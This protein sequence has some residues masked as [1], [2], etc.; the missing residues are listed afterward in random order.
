MAYVPP[1]ARRGQASTPHS[2][3]YIALSEISSYV[4][5]NQPGKLDGN[6]RNSSSSSFSPSSEQSRSTKRFQAVKENRF[7]CLSNEFTGLVLASSSQ[8]S[9]SPS[10]L[11]SSS[12]GSSLGRGGPYTAQEV[13]EKRAQHSTIHHILTETQKILEQALFSWW[14]AKQGPQQ[15]YDEN[16]FIPEDVELS[17]WLDFIDRHP[18]EGNCRF[19]ERLKGS[20]RRMRNHAAH[21]GR[22]PPHKVEHMLIDAKRV[23]DIL[24]KASKQSDYVHETLQILE[25]QQNMLVLGKAHANKN[26]RLGCGPLKSE[27]SAQTAG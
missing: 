5:G 2:E 23:L 7:S 22:P 15:L 24:R 1:A 17:E 27:E 3:G 18:I 6:W 21:R 19:D 20:L 16:K 26:W 25:F 4:S 11:S 12:E 13:E 8:M 10:Y 9:K 14:H